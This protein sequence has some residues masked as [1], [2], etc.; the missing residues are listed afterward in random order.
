[1]LYVH[2]SCASTWG[3]VSASTGALPGRQASCRLNRLQL[4]LLEPSSHVPSLLCSG[5]VTELLDDVM[6]LRPHVFVSV[7]RLWNRIYDRVRACCHSSYITL[8][9]SVP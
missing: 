4:W 6:T 3:P 5:N 1:V 9:H 7:P 2:R 8:L